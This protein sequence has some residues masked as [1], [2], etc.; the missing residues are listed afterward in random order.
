MLKAQRL[1]CIRQQ[2]ILFKDLSF[3]LD[4][5]QLLLVEGANGSGKSSLLRLLTGLSSPTF[6]EIYWQHQSIS[7]VRDL[8]QTHLHYIGHTNGLQ[9]GLTLSE[10][11]AWIAELT[12]QAVSPEKETIFEALQ[13][14]N[15]LHLPIHQLSAGQK[16]RAVLAKLFLFKRS[17]W[18][19]DEPLTALDKQSQDVCLDY[20]KHH[21]DEGGLAIV[22]SHHFIQLPTITTKK[23][24]L[25]AC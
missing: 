8:Y 4:K 9:S 1:C 19:L 18:I 17:F 24:R 7:K 3:S 20:L 5:G 21:L 14:A 25:S 15:A 13:L 16:R 23:I 10:N 6:G 2:K 11:Y 22:S 12:G